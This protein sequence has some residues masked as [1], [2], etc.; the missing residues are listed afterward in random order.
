MTA[1]AKV[2]HGI[3]SI[4]EAAEPTEVHE[5]AKQVGPVLLRLMKHRDLT[6]KEGRLMRAIKEICP[7]HWTDHPSDF[8]TNGETCEIC[9]RPK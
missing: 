9:G 7:C 8:F 1:L 5:W 6:L 4:P 2:N 3:V